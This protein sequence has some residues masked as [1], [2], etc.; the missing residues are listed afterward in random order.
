MRMMMGSVPEIGRN[1]VLIFALGGTIGTIGI[2]YASLYHWKK[3]SVELNSVH[4]INL[5]GYL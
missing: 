4:I 2:A 1:E 5:K 3:R